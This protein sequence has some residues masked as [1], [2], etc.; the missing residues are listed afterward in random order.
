MESSDW[1]HYRNHLIVARRGLFGI[2]RFEVWDR[3]TLV[4]TFRN[5][6]RAELHVDARLGRD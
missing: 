4:G 5:V 6:V 1:R 3:G 2:K